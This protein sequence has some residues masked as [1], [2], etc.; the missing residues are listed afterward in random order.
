MVLCHE[1]LE[2]LGSIC[3]LTLKARLVKGSKQEIVSIYYLAEGSTLMQ[4]QKY[5]MANHTPAAVEVVD[6]VE[7]GVR[8]TGI[9]GKQNG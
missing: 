4:M 9:R 5:L 2:P 3:C 8:M 6:G 1:D 7:D